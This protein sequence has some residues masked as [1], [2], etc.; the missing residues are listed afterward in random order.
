MEGRRGGGETEID[1]RRGIGPIFIL[2]FP[3]TRGGPL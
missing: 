3:R 1:R 2:N